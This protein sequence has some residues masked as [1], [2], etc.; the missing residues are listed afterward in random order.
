MEYEYR[1]VEG[2]G[3]PEVQM[4]CGGKATEGMD[5]NSIRFHEHLCYKF[6]GRFHQ[7]GYKFSRWY[8]M[9]WMEKMLGEHT[10]PAPAIIP[11]AEMKN[12]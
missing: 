1:L 8:D 10:M 4:I 6:V 5:D 9:V 12:D 11:F 7:C 3:L 2:I